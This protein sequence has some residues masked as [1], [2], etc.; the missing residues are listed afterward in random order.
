V[1]I[2]S[3]AGHP[4]HI[5]TVAGWQWDEW[6]HLE[7]G[8]SHA[9]RVAAL[10][11]QAACPGGIPVTLVAVDGDTVLGSV[12]VEDGMPAPRPRLVRLYVT[13]VA[14]GRGIATALVR[15]VMDEAAALG[16]PRLYLFTKGV[17]GLY[18]KTG[19][20]VLEV[21]RAD[22]GELTIMAADLLPESQPM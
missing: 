10:R 4:E 18:E 2:A 5:E 17:R 14:R 15:R 3:I 16:V 7:P 8:N 9:A 13:P 20:R 11:A 12:S 22:G 6:G 1:R 21:R 19:W